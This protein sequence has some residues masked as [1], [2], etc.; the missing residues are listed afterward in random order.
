MIDIVNLTLKQLLEIAALIPQQT[1]QAPCPYPVGENVFIRTVT[2]HYT[3]RLVAV[4]PQELVL[5]D[6]AWIADD[7]RFAEALRSG[8]LNEVEPFPDGNVVIGRGSV[9]DCCR[10]AH[11]LPRTTK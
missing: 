7:G 2:H 5:Q 9:I 1:T 4:G 6:A 3:G 11:P 8:T 10:W